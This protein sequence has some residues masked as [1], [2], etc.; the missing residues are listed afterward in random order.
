MSVTNNSENRPVRRVGVWLDHRV[1]HFV[2]ISGDEVRRKDIVSAVEKKH[3]STG[4]TR[5]GGKTF[6]KSFAASEKHRDRVREEHIRQFY[7]SVLEELRGADAIVIIGP[8]EA[9]AELSSLLM[10]EHGLAERMAGVLPASAMT[11]RQLVAAVKKL[12]H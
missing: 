6:V 10:Q 2:E 3:R 11:E 7:E 1:A 9:K 12:L 5:M 8:G 4:G